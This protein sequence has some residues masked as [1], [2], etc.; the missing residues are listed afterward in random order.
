MRVAVDA[1]STRGQRTGIGVYT[2]ALMEALSELGI[3]LA[4]VD[5]DAGADLRTPRR[6]V[7]EQLLLPRLLGRTGAEIGHLTGFAAPARA[8]VPVVLTVHDLAGRTRPQDLPPV[9]RFYWGRYL[10]TT[11]R[12]AARVIAPSKCTRH[13]LMRETGVPPGRISVVP[14]GYDPRFVAMPPPILEAARARL[15]LPERFFLFVGTLEPRKGVDTLVN[16]FLGAADDVA[17]DLVLAGRDGRLADPL[18]ARANRSSAGNRV[19]FLGYVADADLPALYNLA[20]AVVMPSR[21]EGF[22]LPILEAMASGA[23]VVA[24]TAGALPEVAGDAALLVEPGDVG[25]LARA[26][27]RVSREESL[28]GELRERGFERCRL[29]SWQRTAVETVDVYEE[30]LAARRA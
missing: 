8:S 10:P 14:Y 18:R 13:D 29:F 4:A 1:S 25:A 20:R 9:S 23:P 22:G 11:V 19:R 30:V 2:A 26:L 5:D 27:Q 3:E 7:R 17:E 6:I 24:T 15:A 16:A 21:H 12:Y 28:H